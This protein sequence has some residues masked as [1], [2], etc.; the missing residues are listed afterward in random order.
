[1]DHAQWD[2]TK[3]LFFSALEVPESERHAFLAREC[4]GD[5]ATFDAVLKLLT[6]DARTG[7]PIDRHIGEVAYDVLDGSVPLVRQIGRYRIE[8]IL[9]KGGMG[10]VYLGVRDDLQS[11]VAIKVLRDAALSPL[12]RE[13]F[14]REERLLAQ[15]NHHAIARLFDADVLPDGTPYFVMEYVEG[16]ALTTFCDLHASS[17]RERLVLLREVCAAVQHAHRQALI[18]RDLK[19][20]NILVVR[21]MDGGAPAVKL[22]DFGI[23]RELDD[24]APSSR[25]V[26]SSRLMT[27]AY[28]APE[29]RRGEQVGVYTDVYAL[30]VILYELLTGE[31]PFDAHTRTRGETEALSLDQPPEKPSL[32]AQRGVGQPNLPRFSA[33]GATMWSDLDVLCLTAMHH[34]PQRRY[35]TVEALMRDLDHFLHGEPLEA[36]PDTV[37]YRAGKFVRRH[38]TAVVAASL[39]TIAAIGLITF[40]TV[41]LAAARDAAVSEAARIERLQRFTSQLFLGPDG[42]TLPETAQVGDMLARG[43]EKIQEYRQEPAFQS[44]LYGT[45]GSISRQMGNFPRADSLLQA[46]LDRNRALYGSEHVDVAGNMIALGVLRMDEAKYDEAERLVRDGL[47]IARRNAAPNHPTVIEGVNALGMIHVQ[48][49]KYAEAITELEEAIRRQTERGADSIAISETTNLLANAHYFAGHY[50]TAEKL[51]R[52]VLEFDRKRLGLHPSVAHSLVNLGNL[53]YERERYEEAG[54]LYREALAIDEKYN[55]PEHLSTARDLL[56]V[57]RSLSRRANYAEARPLITRS[58]AL[59]TKTYGPRHPRTAIALS[60]LAWIETKTRNFVAAE[61]LLV[62]TI[63]I[64]RETLGDEHSF[65]GSATALLATA[66]ADQGKLELAERNYREAVRI[67]TIALTADNVVTAAAQVKLGRVLLRERSYAD[68]EQVLVAASKVLVAHGE[69]SPPSALRDAHTDLQAVYGATGRKVADEGT[70]KEL[71]PSATPVKP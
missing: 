5:D 39:G 49:G 12:R 38:R 51:N 31:L 41:R 17:L 29:Q 11:R 54:T 57:S 7:S 33:P 60:E 42:V 23:A 18:H 61:S 4:A 67:L 71:V 8:S 58:L 24:L 43:I 69:S 36:R 37:G 64:C 25:L 53:Q 15:L 68:A 1:M 13:W 55:G 6:A 63:S 10:V 46:S 27:P 16:E 44:Q 56:L 22:L 2:R 21:A 3:T 45:L 9:G 52:Q 34:D 66:Y 32:R 30:G 20:S 19:P 26:T 70:R 50:D 40:Y 62:R 48:S 47:A 35:Q 59:Y 28:A 14:Q 65:V